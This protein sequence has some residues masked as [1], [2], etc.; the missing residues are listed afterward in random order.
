MSGNGKTEVNFT[1]EDKNQ[2]LAMLNAEKMILDPSANLQIQDV[3]EKFAL[4]TYDLPA[5]KEGN[6]ARAEFINKARYL[7]AVMR[8]ESV[9]I[10]PWSIVNELAVFKA[11]DVGKVRIFISVPLH[12][13]DCAE[14]TREY[15]KSLNLVFKDAEVRFDKIEKH[16][17]EQQLGLVH[18]MLPK[19]EEQVA[20]LKKA[21]IARGSQFLYDRWEALDKKL[22]V[23]RSFFTMRR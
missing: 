20:S 7:G 16:L 14:I 8:T 18:K 13:E 15:D 9:Y 10:A 3:M 1:D 11:A 5:T 23:Y 21:A 4:I 6:E 2:A 12:K 22:S 19:T 17:E